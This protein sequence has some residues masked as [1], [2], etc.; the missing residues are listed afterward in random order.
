[1][2]P[3]DLMAWDAAAI[4]VVAGFVAVLKR[5]LPQNWS[6]FL[7]LVSIALGIVYAMTYRPGC[8]MS[9]ECMFAGFQVGL[10]A[11]GLHS[12]F[13]NATEKPKAS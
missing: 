7:P 13:K 12:S 6:A 3:T 1:M 8:Q 5:R 4:P 2:N 10:M 11:T 9:A